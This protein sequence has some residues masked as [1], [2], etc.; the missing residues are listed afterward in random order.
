MS[1]CKR[2][3]DRLKKGPLTKLE[4]INNLG[5]LNVGARILELRQKGISVKTEMIPVK[6]RFGESCRVAEYMLEQ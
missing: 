5:I 4:A 2:L 1:Q 3:H 6:N